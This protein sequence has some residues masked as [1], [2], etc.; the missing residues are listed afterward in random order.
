M[1]RQLN[2]GEIFSIPLL[3]G[4]FGFGYT[5]AERHAIRYCDIIDFLGDSPVPPAN[6]RELPVVLRDL[7]AMDEFYLPRNSTQGERWRTTGLGIDRPVRPQERYI[8]MEMPFRRIDLLNEEP[9]VPLSPEDFKE[10]RVLS[11]SGAPHAAA[12]VEIAIKRL[13]LTPQQ[14]IDKWRARE[15]PPPRSVLPGRSKPKAHKSKR[16]TTFHVAMSLGSNDFPSPAQLATRHAFEDLV[17][18]RKLGKIVDAGAG[19]GVMDVFVKLRSAS[20]AE[21]LPG[22]LEEAGLRKEDVKLEPCD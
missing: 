2:V 13:D 8:R 7:T 11:V 22:L 15:L 20:M 6:V 12:V 18:E 16:T 21:Q 5:T 3:G 9:S 19:G 4:G 1:T 14:L 10:Y 17:I